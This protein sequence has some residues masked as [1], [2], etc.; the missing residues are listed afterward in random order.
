MKVVEFILYFGTGFVD[1]NFGPPAMCPKVTENVSA[2]KLKVAVVDPRMSKS[3]SRAL[4][5]LPVKPT[6]DAALAL[7]MIQWIIAN[8]RYD[9]TYLAAA[10]KAAAKAVK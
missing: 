3:A 6:T 5:W 8:K 10:N 2:G 1:A 9:A 4:K 7:A